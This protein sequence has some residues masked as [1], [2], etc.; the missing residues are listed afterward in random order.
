M[1]ES[2][3]IN[4]QPVNTLYKTFKPHSKMIFIVRLYC[5]DTGGGFILGD[6]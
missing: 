2:S 5:F 6:S 1:T 3:W 4:K